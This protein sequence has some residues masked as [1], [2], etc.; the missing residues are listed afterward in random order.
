MLTFLLA[1]QAE[2]Q[3]N[4]ES[5]VPCYYLD[6]CRLYKQMAQHTRATYDVMFPLRSSLKYM[7]QYGICTRYG[8]TV[9]ENIRNYK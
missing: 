9:D 7:S 2:I 1:V 4:R 3:E 8:A 6:V 5:F